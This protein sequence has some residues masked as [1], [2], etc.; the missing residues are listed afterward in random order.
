[1]GEWNF[2]E[3]SLT[4]FYLIDHFF[5]WATAGDISWRYQIFCMLWFGFCYNFVFNS[6]LHQF[7]G[8]ALK[9]YLLL[10]NHGY[11]YCLNHVE[12]KEYITRRNKPN[13]QITKFEVG[14]CSPCGV[15]G[16]GRD[17]AGYKSSGVSHSGV[18]SSRGVSH[19]GVSWSQFHPKMDFRNM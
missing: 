12:P 7:V 9:F 3:W 17:S 4:M 5:G 19:S 14:H 2:E 13:Q 11:L 16:M 8:F 1:M 15:M 6:V 10:G 18:S